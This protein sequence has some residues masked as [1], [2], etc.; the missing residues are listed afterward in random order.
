MIKN[1][2]TVTEGEMYRG[3]RPGEEDYTR[4]LSMMKTIV[5][6][7]GDDVAANEAASM[8]IHE[9]TAKLIWFPISISD[10][11]V[12]G[13]PP[14]LLNNLV[15]QIKDAPAPVFIHCQHGQDRTGLVVAAWRI[16]CGW[17]PQD[18]F[19]EAVSLGYKAHINAGLNRNFKMLGVNL[20]LLDVAL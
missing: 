13:V 17:K 2:H 14:E 20:P 8:V 3:A 19:E 1:F 6:L 11:Y 15:R 18:A 12:E 16:S 7:E 9:C 5:N 4:A 10:I